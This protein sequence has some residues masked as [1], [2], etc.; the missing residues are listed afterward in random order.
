MIRFLF[1][2]QTSVTENEDGNNTTLA[3]ANQCG[4]PVPYTGDICSRELLSVMECFPEDSS[5][6]MVDLQVVSVSSEDQAQTLVGAL[7]QFGSPEC[8]AAATPFLCVYLFRGVCDDVNGTHYFPTAA[9]CEEISSGVCREEFRLARSFG[10]DIV[11][12]ATLPTGPPSLCSTNSSQDNV[13][14]RTE[15]ENGN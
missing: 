14:L 6:M 12:C 1:P 10:M 8:V 7:Q 4:S 3:T 9:E 13:R 11:D 15:N 5:L 2:I